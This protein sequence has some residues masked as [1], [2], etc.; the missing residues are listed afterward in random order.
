M[1]APPP[2]IS[3]SLATLLRF[4]WEG[5]GGVKLLP[6][7]SAT[8]V[9]ENLFLEISKIPFQNILTFD[10]INRPMKK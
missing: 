1:W 5:W 9:A 6:N 2:Q 3:L 4:Q 8:V 7:F 10:L